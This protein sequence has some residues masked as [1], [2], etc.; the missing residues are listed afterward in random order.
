MRYGKYH[1]LS[2]PAIILENGARYWWVNN[3]WYSKT[4]HN[5]LVLFFILEPLRIDLVPKEDD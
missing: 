3:K 2:G 5:R 4:K 1:R